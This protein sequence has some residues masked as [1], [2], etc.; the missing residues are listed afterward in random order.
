M[1]NGVTKLY[2]GWKEAV[3]QIADR[4]NREG[5][6]V[7][8]SHEDLHKMMD[9]KIPET[10]THEE[11]KKRDLEIMASIVNL[12][13]TLLKEHNICLK[14]VRG[15]GYMVLTPDDQVSIGVEQ[16]WRK[17]GRLVCKA[18]QKAVCVNQEALSFEGQQMQVRQMEKASFFRAAMS[19]KKR[20]VGGEK[21][22]LALTE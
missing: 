18:V 3:D 7:M 20:V 9:I 2:P 6:G 17:I 5:Y 10:G 8:F 21:E 14:N 22:S 19:K 4:V 11:Y 15:Q 1:Q 16:E 12:T 13:D